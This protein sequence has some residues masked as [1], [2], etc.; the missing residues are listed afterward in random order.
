MKSRIAKTGCLL[1]VVC[2]LIGIS[3]LAGMIMSSVNEVSHGE[4]ALKKQ[5]YHLNS[6]ITILCTE[7]RLVGII[8]L[9]QCFKWSIP[10]NARNCSTS[11][12]ARRTGGLK[13]SMLRTSVRLLA[14]HGILILFRWRMILNLTPG[15]I[16]KHLNQ[17]EVLSTKH[18]ACLNQ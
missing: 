13:R 3:F 17:A 6:R 7:Y 15:T 14:T 4:Y 9:R 1:V 16:L 5:V 2:F 10:L 12:L 8:F 11:C 18:R